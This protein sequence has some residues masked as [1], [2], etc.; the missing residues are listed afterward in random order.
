MKTST[1]L[2]EQR[3]QIN[4]ELTALEKGFEG[5]EPTAEQRSAYEAKLKEVEKLTSDIDFAERAEKS[6][7]ERAAQAVSGATIVSESKEESRAKSEWSLFKGVR[8]LRDRGQLSGL[9]KELRDEAQREAIG[10]G[11]HIGGV[12]V[13]SFMLE[14]RTDIDQNTSAIQ[15]TLVLGYEKALRES[16][17]H[18]AVG[19]RTLTGLTAD[20]KIPIVGKQSLAWATA[21]NSAAADGGANFTTATLSPTRLTGYVDISNKV[22]L[23]NGMGAQMIVMEDLGYATAA[24]IDAAMFST[25]NVSNAPGSI[26]ATSGVN[27]F[28]ETA[29]YAANVSIF[30][31]LVLAEQTLAGAEG[32]TGSLAYVG[33]TN[34]LADLKQSAQ[35]SNVNPALQGNM[36]YNQQMINGYRMFYTV[37]ATKSAGVSGDFIFGDFSKVY[38]GFFGGLDIQIDPYTVNINDQIRL[39]VHRYVDWALTHGAG[40][41]KATSLVA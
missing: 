28:T 6:K 36:A 34:L 37:G 3:G 23:Q 40:F 10:L 15:P 41:V 27:T 1:E 24:K 16:S 26:A 5:V 29:T 39:V 30:K 38:L 4:E 25:A 17:I 12:G 22:L 31:D 11:Q 21:E 13:P 18:S 32:L 14:K 2:R 35:V 20:Y 9:E 33:A 8:E 19:C 7:A